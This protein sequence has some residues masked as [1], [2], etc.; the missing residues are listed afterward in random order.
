MLARHDRDCSCACRGGGPAE[1]RPQDGAARRRRRGRRGG[2]SGRALGEAVGEPAAGSDPRVSGGVSRVPGRPGR[3]TAGHGDDPGERVLRPDWTFWEHNCTHLDVPAHFVTGGRF[4]PRS[5]RRAR[6]RSRRRSRIDIAPTRGLRRRRHTPTPRGRSSPTSSRS[7]AARGAS[8]AAAVVAMDSAGR[9]GPGASRRI[10]TSAP[11]AAALPGLLEAA[12]EWLLEE[13]D[14][15]GIGVDTL[16]LDPGRSQTFDAHVDDCSPRRTGTGSRTSPTSTGSRRAAPRSPSGWSRGSRARAARPASSPA[17]EACGAPAPAG[18][19]RQNSSSISCWR[20]GPRAAERLDRRVE[21]I[22]LRPIQPLQAVVSSGSDGAG[23][24]RPSASVATAWSSETARRSCG[25]RRRRRRSRAPG[26][27]RDS[28]RSRRRAATARAQVRSRAI[29][30]CA[31]SSGTGRAVSLPASTLSSVQTS[32][33][34]TRSK[35]SFS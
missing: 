13:R 14:I 8:R 15:A 6:R 5:A 22:A 7:S 33:S 29:R 20:C 34:R 2:A 31:C 12:V 17:G 35:P 16:S 23:R 9:R 32:S 26:R 4:S 18:A 1:A 25:R 21:R 28:R 27:R 10:A 3:S 24:V 11:T 30:V 19:P